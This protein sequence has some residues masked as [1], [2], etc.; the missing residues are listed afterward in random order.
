MSE[1]L[2][3]KSMP[4]I[5]IL[6][7]VSGIFW[8]ILGVYLESTP[9]V[10]AGVLASLGY[11]VAFYTYSIGYS[12]F[13]RSFM[14][15]VA[16]VAITYGTFNVPNG[17]F[18]VLMLLGL[19]PLMGIIF[20]RKSEKPLIVGVA[21][22]NIVV[23]AYIILS[24]PLIVFEFSSDNAFEHSFVAISVCFTVVF[25][26]GTSIIFAVKEIDEKTMLL[27]QSEN[28]LMEAKQALESLV[29]YDD[30]T[31]IYSRRWLNTRFGDGNRSKDATF[32]MIDIDDFKSVNDEYGHAAGDL[33]LKGIAEALSKKT[34][35]LGCAM[36]LGGEEFAIIRPWKNES[37]AKK[38]GEELLREIQSVEIK[39]NET[40]MH[41]TASIGVAKLEIGA[42]LSDIMR[43]ADKSLYKAKENGGNLCFI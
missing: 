28:E 37:E 17:G 15:V 24:H 20:D 34:E 30:L 39:H 23:F 8:A 25:V 1:S 14:F 22:T 40:K 11:L 36:R 10:I 6:L 3:T 18:I 19:I 33:L 32:Y 13:G 31:G 5:T 29:Y 2:N 12:K 4:L 9:A 35:K 41:R 27:V 43:N 38:F 7:F 42:S 16:D 21:L 26:A